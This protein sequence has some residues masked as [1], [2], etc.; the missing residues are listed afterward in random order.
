M[1]SVWFIWRNWLSLNLSEELQGVKGRCTLPGWSKP[2][3]P[4]QGTCSPGLRPLPQ[5]KH[6]VP[7]C[8]QVPVESNLLHHWSCFRDPACPSS[9]C[10]TASVNAFPRKLSL[11]CGLR[12]RPTACEWEHSTESLNRNLQYQLAVTCHCWGL[13]VIS[14]ITIAKPPA[15]KCF[16]YF[17]AT[18]A[19]S[20][21][22]IKKFLNKAHH[23]PVPIAC[24]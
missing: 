20:F 19:D 18:K 16:S 2:L 5:A 14:S 9:T 21:T 23:P 13:Q 12:L 3:L 6:C 8:V 7:A 24:E 15:T 4:T 17:P 22:F 1:A 11:F 10:P